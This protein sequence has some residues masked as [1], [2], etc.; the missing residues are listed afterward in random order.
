[1][2]KQEVSMSR[3]IAFAGTLLLLFKPGF[4]QTQ[5]DRGKYLAMGVAMCVQCH[6]PRNDRGE[7]IED[8]LFLGAPIPVEAP[9]RDWAI[10]A[11]RIARLPGWTDADFVRLLQTGKRPNGS[12][13]RRPM[14]PFRMNREDASA[15]ASF[16]KALKTTR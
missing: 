14:P 13:P 6:S 3:S 8:Q 1:V 10:R 11:P 5:T 12:S 16:L 7:L 2:G 9:G 4:A 15:I